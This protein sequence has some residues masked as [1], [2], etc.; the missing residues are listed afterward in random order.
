MTA[1]R[2]LRTF[3]AA[4]LAASAL[5]LG[6]CSS[7]PETQPSP[8][9]TAP[10]APTVMADASSF[11]DAAEEAVVT[12]KDQ[13]LVGAETA[14]D[15]GIPMFFDGSNTAAQLEKLGVTKVY[16]AGNVGTYENAETLEKGASASEPFGDMQTV[17]GMTPP[18][19]REL[20][21]LV[22]AETGLADIAT[23]RA[24][25]A[26][27]MPLAVG[28]P[29]VTK[30]SMDAVSKGN[31]VALGPAFGT[32]ENFDRRVELAANGELPGDG[33]LVF[34]GRRMVALYGHPSGPALGVM[35]EQDPAGSVAKAKEL[36]A[37]YQELTDYPVIPAFEVIATVASGGPGPDGNYSN[38]SDPVELEP[39]VDAI[40]D[41]GGYAVLDLQPGRASLLE[42]AK[43]YEDLLSRPNVGL[44]LDPEWKIG[45]DELPMENVGHVEAAE[46]NEVA[47]WLA[48]LVSEKKLP[49]KALVLHQFQ[50]QMIRDRENVNTDHPELAFVLHADGHGPTDVKMETWNMMR[51]GLSPNYFMAW[52]NF[53]DEDHPMLTPEGTFSVEPRPWF[54][55]YQ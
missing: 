45:P 52:K 28:D 44:A 8:E 50:Q 46:V 39:Y 32:Q 55:S 1:V 38:E 6:S 21:A 53:I 35:G 47:D 14:V 7:T 27:V 12:D 3:S 31:V 16:T 13:A 22:T 33:G 19:T 42:Q 43:R 29:R 40:V 54:V 26:T 30:A 2:S 24:A 10:S 5:A 18:E 4:V 34:P 25:G 51:E 23:A 48:G 17:A 9:T 36:A 20:T 37:Q 11:F 49:Q 15:K 41:A